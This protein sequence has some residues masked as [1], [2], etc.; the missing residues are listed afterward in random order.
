MR[1]SKIRVR[2]RTLDSGCLYSG[3]APPLIDINHG[4]GLSDRSTACG[5]HIVTMPLKRERRYRRRISTTVSSSAFLL[6]SDGCS[7]ISNRARRIA[8][9]GHRHC[10]PPLVSALPSDLLHRRRQPARPDTFLG[11]GQLVPPPGV[12]DRKIVQG[13]HAVGDL[14]TR[15]PGVGVG[16]DLGLLG[17]QIG[18]I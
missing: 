2:Q 7:F 8:S 13:D 18:A 5:F 12:E 17:E 9:P 10:P 1:I 15:G 3:E 11:I 6:F 14:G 4:C 16:L